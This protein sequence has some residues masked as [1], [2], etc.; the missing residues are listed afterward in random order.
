MMTSWLE[1]PNQNNLVKMSWIEHPGQNILVGTSW[2][3]HPGY[4]TLV[5]T[6]WSVHRTC[7]S[8]LRTSWSG[9][10]FSWLECPGQNA[11]QNTL[12]QKFCPKTR[13]SKNV[14]AI[15]RSKNMVQKMP[16]TVMKCHKLEMMKLTS[17]MNF[18]KTVHDILQLSE[19]G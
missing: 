14:V 5:R 9:L 2:L 12:S 10:R 13:Q 8:E 11:F 15:K 3:E 18:K 17:G 19:L 6:S 7:W 1:C 4:N 16:G